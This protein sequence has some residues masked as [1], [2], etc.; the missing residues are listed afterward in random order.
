MMYNNGMATKIK[1]LYDP[2]EQENV[3]YNIKYFISYIMVNQGFFGNNKLN[4]FNEVFYSISK[5][6]VIFCYKYPKKI[7]KHNES[8][9]I[10]L[11]QSFEE[12][13]RQLQ[14]SFKY[15]YDLTKKNNEKKI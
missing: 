9:I 12:F 6:E 3:N 7:N 1:Y 14:T 15:L 11:N 5:T 8:M 13:Q 2:K 4:I 10:P